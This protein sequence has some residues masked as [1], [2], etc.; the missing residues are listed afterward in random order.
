MW[1]MYLNMSVPGKQIKKC[2]KNFDISKILEK[3]HLHKVNYKNI[4]FG[5]TPK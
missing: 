3:K 5:R 4:I 1:S 2:E